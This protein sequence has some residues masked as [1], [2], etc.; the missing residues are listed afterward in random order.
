MVDEDQLGA[1]LGRHNKTGLFQFAQIFRGG[2][3]FSDACFLDKADLAVG[4]LEDQI[5][6]FLA[7]HY[8]GQGTL[9]CVE[10]FGEQI[11]NG[12]DF[13]GS[14]VRRRFNRFEHIHEPGFPF[15]SF[16]YGAQA[17]V[18]LRSVLNDKAVAMVSLFILRRSGRSSLFQSGA[19]DQL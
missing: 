11:A 2:Q 6:Q 16:R 15:A 14:A 4:L 13:F 10:S 3:P 19:P 9:R 17:A 5:D 1:S 12:V 8:F 18:V 7:E